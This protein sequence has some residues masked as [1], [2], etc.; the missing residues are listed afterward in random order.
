MKRLSAF[1][2]AVG[3]FLAMSAYAVNYCAS[4]SWGNA[5]T[6]VTGGGNATPTLVSS[7]SELKSALGSKAK[8]K[9]VI[10]T[11]NLT[12]TSML[13][14]QDA[15]NITLMALPGV[16]LVSEKQDATNSGILYVK[17]S[18]NV[19]FRNLTFEGP[20]AYDCDG[21][22][23]LCF[24]KVTNAWVD[25]CD[26]QDGCDGNFDNKSTTDNV[27]VSWC[28][29]RY[30]KEPRAGG[31]GGAAD[32]RFTNLLGSS[33]SDKPSDGTYNFTWAYC[34]WDEG[35]VERM[36][37]CR[38]AELHFLNCY[39]NSSVAN[40]YVGPE[41][42]KAYFEG[43]TFEGKA[44]SSSKIFKSYG[45]TN[46]C[47]FVNCSGKLP[48]NSGTVS[49]PSY[50][51]DQLS[52]ADAKSYVTNST[53]GAGA[54]LVVTSAG[55]VSSS[56]DGGSTPITYYI[57]T[58]D[59]A[60][61]G[62]S[63]SISTSQVQAGQAVGTLPTATKSGYTFNGWFTSANNGDKISASTIIN[64]NITYYAQYTEESGGG[65]TSDLTWNFSTS[66]F[67]GLGTI[68]ATTTVNGLTITAASDKAVT[69]A[70]GAKTIDGINFTHVL[71]TGG[72]GS[73]TARNLNFAVTGPCNIEVYLVS[74]KSSETRTLNIFAGSYSSTPITTMSA[75]GSAAK[76]TYDY[77]GGATTIYMGSMNSGINF[78]AINLVYSGE[79]PPEPTPTYTLTYDE[80]GGDGTMEEQTVDE[81]QS[82]TVL[83]NAFTAPTG[84]SFKEWNTNAK[85]SGA[86]YTVGQ[87]VT[88]TEDIT[89]Y[90]VWQANTYT[91]TLNAGEGT[92]GTASVQA[93]FDA[94]MPNISIPSRNGYTFKGYFSEANGAGTQYYDA[95]GSSTNSWVTPSDATLYAAWEEQ[96]GE[97]PVTTGDLH[98]WF[99]YAP[100]AETNNVENDN[101]V[102]SNMVVSGSQMAG[103]ITIDGKSY[104]V[105]R[106]TGDTQVFGNFTIP[107]NKKA[108]FYALAVSSGGADRQINLINGTTKYEFS[109]PGGS[110]AYQRIESDSLPAGTYSI[111][112]EGSSNVR[113]AIV[114]LKICDSQGGTE[115]PTPVIYTVTWN[116]NGG[117][118]ATETTTIEE[119]TAL[120]ELPV[121][122]KENHTFDGWFTAAEGGE[123]ISAETIITQ[124]TTFYAHY[125]ENQ[126][127][128]TPISDS[129]TWNFSKAE[130]TALIGDIT[131]TKVINGLTLVA[132]S[133]NKMSIDK[134][135][136]AV[137]IGDYTFTHRLKTNG[138][139]KT[140][141]RH[142][143]FDVTGACTIE[144]YL[145][146]ASSDSRTL[147]IFSG[148]FGGTPIGTLAAPP[149]TPVKQTYNYTGE[150]TT[151][152][153][154]S[155]SSGINFYGI[156]I[157]YPSPTP[158]DIENV[159]EKGAARKVLRNGQV[160]IIRDDKTYTIIGTRVE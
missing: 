156:N 32:H 95:N 49:A 16:K 61:N 62:G 35:C 101:T 81:G 135:S 7:V 123:Q 103:S 68:S 46:A 40:Y 97:T 59:A 67:N 144:V 77:T 25:H 151:L 136:Q 113:M 108:I 64:G 36:V 14:I 82:V 94:A 30:L 24:E 148:S 56:C 125:T 43:C 80:N 17:R 92:G 9:V 147:N 150:A 18:S 10:I 37:R 139:G 87:S 104:S 149:T 5:G 132:T 107:E 19:L 117:E 83:A 133:G 79:T 47:K 89:L 86:K 90:A 146:S 102:F 88:M 131:E 39:W 137:T 153:L 58:W 69:V 106:R 93:T 126:T 76:Q 157:I 98:F 152:Y 23:L 70:E 160:L 118:C 52:A 124:D 45:G 121:A 115:P 159:A 155:A 48:S 75:G 66:D 54:T 91:V 3:L 78:Y 31:S 72:S 51:Y 60:T 105:S 65:T 71:K 109:V 74:A 12:F 20:G 27:T 100:D 28:R 99:F 29:F 130:F 50:S 84:Y 41:N 34:W 85:G 138:T 22:D 145:V 158:T 141:Y 57:V 42:A 114:V 11:K 26:F 119:N 154:G 55:A 73:A 63:C 128:P 142:L 15:Q 116:A 4:S 6:S 8:N 143:K 134:P 120:G 110:S 21:N 33:S 129:L 122:S 2:C 127:P 140:D 112:R 53:C 1:F 96:S 13:T 44:N 111:E 38:N